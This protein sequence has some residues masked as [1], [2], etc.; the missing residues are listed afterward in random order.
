LAMPFRM[1][2]STKIVGQR[3]GL[4][5]Y[6]PQTSNA[7]IF[8]KTTS[9]PKKHRRVKTYLHSS[10]VSY[11]FWYGHHLI[12]PFLGHPLKKLCGIYKQLKCYEPLFSYAAI[13]PFTGNTLWLC[14]T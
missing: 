4:W 3:D 6:M 10:W 9:T 12:S 1:I 7:S 2:Y 13:L 5:L 14:L 8:W 11:L